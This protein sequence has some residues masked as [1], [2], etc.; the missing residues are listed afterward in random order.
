M[1]R[2]NSSCGTCRL[3]FRVSGL[4]VERHDGSF[5]LLVR[6]IPIIKHIYT[7]RAA[8]VVLKKKKVVEGFAFRVEGSG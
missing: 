5:Q 2:L 4:G 8:P 3:G 6:L 1:A 7:P